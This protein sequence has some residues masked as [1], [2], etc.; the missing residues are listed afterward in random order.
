MLNDIN[1]QYHIAKSN[2]EIA[3]RR[4]FTFSIQ[5]RKNPRPINKWNLNSSLEPT[6]LNK[7]APVKVEKLA[8]ID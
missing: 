7:I 3:K 1:K 5:T 6:Y 4:L 2:G 8:P